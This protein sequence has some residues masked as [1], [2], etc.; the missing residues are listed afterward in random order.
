[1]A[2]AFIGAPRSRRRYRR[3]WRIKAPS[4]P[5]RS[6]PASAPTS[7]TPIRPAVLPFA[8][9][10]ASDVRILDKGRLV[11]SG[12]IAELTDDLVQ[13]HLTV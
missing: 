7:S 3:R 11:M 10:V 1:L 12:A 4:R 5:S 6:V 2:V 9:R 13:K 8:R